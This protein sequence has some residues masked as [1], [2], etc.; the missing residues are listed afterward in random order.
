MTL[1][2]CW[3][4]W[5]QL[6][7][8]PE[9]GR[10]NCRVDFKR[11]AWETGRGPTS[12]GYTSVHP[13]F[14]PSFHPSFLPSSSTQHSG[15]W[16]A[17]PIPAKQAS[18]LTDPGFLCLYREKRVRSPAEHAESTQEVDSITWQW[19]SC[20]W[21]SLCTTE[22]PCLLNVILRLL[23]SSWVCGPHTCTLSVV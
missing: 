17:E 1:A 2:G 13:F 19:T 8:C 18:T 7:L 12:E 4:L 21:A 5:L 3:A 10:Q 23:F 16:G 22:A 20:S 6:S 9:G 15:W 14:L 11:P